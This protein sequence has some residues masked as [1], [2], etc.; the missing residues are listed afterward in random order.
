MKIRFVFLMIKPKLDDNKL[1]KIHCKQ[2]CLLFMRTNSCFLEY[3]Y[4]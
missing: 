3:L 4:I 2:N 1:K